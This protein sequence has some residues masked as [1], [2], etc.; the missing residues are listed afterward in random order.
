MLDTAYYTMD[1]VL[2]HKVLFF[3]SSLCDTIRYN[4]LSCRRAE[5]VNI[6]GPLCQFFLEPTGAVWLAKVIWELDNSK[7]DS[8]YLAL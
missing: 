3:F 2:Y 8:G 4:I 5:L 1:S 7:R 6:P